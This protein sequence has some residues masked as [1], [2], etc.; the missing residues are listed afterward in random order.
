M[1]DGGVIADYLAVAAARGGQRLV[2]KTV[3]GA[4]DRLTAAV[5]N[6]LGWRPDEYLAP[7][8][9]DMSARRQVAGAVAEAA[10]RDPQFAQKLDAIQA[11]LDRVGARD[12]INQVNNHGGINAQAFGGGSVHVGDY[13]EGDTHSNDYDPGDELVVGQ[14]SGRLLATL[15]LLVAL[16]GFG[17]W[18]Y[19]IFTGFG[20]EFNGPLDLELLPGIPLA[21]VAFGAILVGGVLYGLGTSISKAARKRVEQQRRRSG[22]HA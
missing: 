17:G 4:L 15:G 22:R 21:P 20:G 5:A 18:M 14:G 16:T 6:R 7:A 12:L 1:I 10:Q 19:L 2:D 8:P 3:N 11:Q 13:F 9:A